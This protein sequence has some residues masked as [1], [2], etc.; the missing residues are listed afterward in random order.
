M[1]PLELLVPIA[2]HWRSLVVVP[3]LAGLVA[4]GASYLIKP[5]YTAG[6]TFLPPQQQQ[7]ALSSAALASLGGTLGGLA[8]GA[9]GLR[10]P[11]DQ[12]ASLLQTLAVRDKLLDEFKL[13][14]VYKAD[15]RV[16]AL[17]DL[18]ERVRIH[19]GKR[20]GLLSVEVDDVSPE[21]AAAMANRHVDLLKSLTSTLTLTEAQQRRAFFEQ[22]LE[23]TRNSLTEAQQA[24]ARSGFSTGSLRAEPR[25][26]AEGYA[27][28]RAETTSLEVR[29]QALRRSLT[30]S[31]PEVQQLLAALASMRGQLAGMETGN[32]DSA[33]ADYIARYREFK[34]QETLL[35]GLARQYELARL[36]ESREG[37]LIQI[38]DAAKVPEKRSRPKRRFIAAAAVAGSFGVLLVAVVGV[39]LFRR[40][41]LDP[42][43]S[44]TLAR[45]KAAIR[46]G[47]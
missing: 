7:S 31:A 8:A 14:E 37:A 23:R 26:S 34:Y 15:F 20:D 42:L 45:A 40:A 46:T 32:A 3:L 1:S 28:L 38:V 5:V 2:R 17:R 16:D 9:A 4:F 47:S 43:H 21:R 18:S 29:L 13:Q 22:Q 19:V 30:D 11:A 35:E 25:A 27:R 10:T 24:L 39:H 36:D 44:E 6:V 41:M 12:Y 33:N